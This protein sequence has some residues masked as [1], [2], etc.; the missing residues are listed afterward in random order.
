MRIKSKLVSIY[1]V[2]AVLIGITVLFVINSYTSIKNDF[3]D[4]MDNPVRKLTTLKNIER[5]ILRMLIS[6][7][8][9]GLLVAE[10][11][12]E[13]HQK[14]GFHKNGIEESGEIEGE[15]IEEENE[16]FEKGY[17]DYSKSIGEYE[18]LVKISA[19]NQEDYFEEIKL[20]GD[21]LI[22]I[23]KEFVLLKK[24]GAVGNEVLEKKEKLEESERAV[25][26]LIEKSNLHQY[27]ELQ[28]KQANVEATIS[29]STK[30]TIFF[31]A[32]SLLITIVGGYIFSHRIT[33]SIHKL[34]EATNKIGQGEMDLD[35]EDKSKDEIGELAGDFRKMLFQLK[36]S[37][38]QIIANKDFV[39]NIFSSMADM[40]LAVD[41]DGKIE[42]VNESV[43]N[44]L[45]FSEAE[46]IG[47]NIKILTPHDTFLTEE[48][49]NLMLNNR[50]LIEIEKEMVRKNG[51]KIPVLIS[52]AILN[53]RRAAAVVVAKDI[54]KL[55]KDESKL[56]NYAVELEISNQEYE[57]LT[58]SYKKIAQD[59]R[60]SEIELIKANNFTNNIMDS[61]VDFVV[62]V[63]LDLVIKRVNPA[64]LKLNGYDEDEMIG[65]SVNIL[66]ADK[67]FTEK[68][69][70]AL[71]KIGFIN[72]I[73]KLNRCKNGSIVPIS[74][75]MSVIK[76]EQG[77]DSA[78]VCVGRDVS[79]SIKARRSIEESNERLRQSN[80]ELEDFAYVA[81]HDLQEPLRKIQAFGDR[82]MKKYSE[83][84]GEEGQDYIS[85]M[86]QAANRM[87]RL[88]NDLLAFSRIT[89][90]AQPFQSVDVKKI[91]DEVISDLE[92]RIEETNGKVEIG[93]LPQ[94][95]ADP[96]QIRQL[97]QNLIGNAL[98]FSQAGKSPQ[99]K[100]YSQ[101]YSDTSA[102][103][104]IDGKS[105]E[106]TGSADK[107]CQII[108][109]DNGIGFDEKYLDKIFTVFQRLHGRTEYEG[110]GVGLA[111]CRKIVERH[112]G[113]ITAKS[114]EGEGS[115]FLITLP[116]KQTHKEE[117][118]NK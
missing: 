115:T 34:Q 21:E 118:I 55:K 8:E 11:K 53:G 101:D 104:V 86:T 26:A 97:M 17:N 116:V 59:L 76:D 65:Q 108:V 78:I 2:G 49:F 80:R 20:I 29:N 111:V 92:V 22:A 100:V 70:L 1:L 110:S 15:E 87:Q 85:R 79:E 7:S 90:K 58:N 95:D 82:L 61:M 36:D 48:E 5:S 35:F 3:T 24:N 42:K 67:G 27:D 93:E 66:I 102:S 113:N 31:S 105:V 109:Q 64:A 62:V 69:V 13:S 18:N 9:Y 14:T 117:I 60:E 57:S 98:K 37:R 23:C 39:E 81:S 75:S 19:N 44:I 63:G 89:T 52:S 73:E 25:L 103:F 16:L 28:K 91:T 71:R 47:K 96:M 114:K 43:L 30:N 46:L 10:K 88:I 51:K 77:N 33:K 112:Q 94:I 74:L 38:N 84:L 56:K 72:N 41:D 6:T 45:G 107:K 99:I 106:T 4:V 54:T 12:E 83:I 32:I 68:G 40:L 50:E